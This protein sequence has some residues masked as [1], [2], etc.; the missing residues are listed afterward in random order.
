VAAITAEG[1]TALYDSLIYALYYFS[2]INGKRAVLLLSD[3][4]T[5]HAGATN[6]YLAIPHFASGCVHVFAQPVA[7]PDNRLKYLI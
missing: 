2:G 3:S 7:K 6:Y 4:R 5:D 1:G